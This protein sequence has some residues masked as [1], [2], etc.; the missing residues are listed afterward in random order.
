MHFIRRQSLSTHPRLRFATA[1][2]PSALSR[3]GAPA[4][5]RNSY[6]DTP[7]GPTQSFLGAAP[8]ATNGQL[9][10]MSTSTQDKP[11]HLNRLAQAKS[12]YLLQHAENPVRRAER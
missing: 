8:P 5:A 9:R 12:P 1:F 11:K 2:H 6:T 4:A 7:R 3:L 10:S